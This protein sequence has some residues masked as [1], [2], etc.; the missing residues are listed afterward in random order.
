MDETNSLEEQLQRVK[1]NL[2][3]V[4]SAVEKLDKYLENF[5]AIRNKLDDPYD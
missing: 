2:T 3:K 1:S 4:K 5:E